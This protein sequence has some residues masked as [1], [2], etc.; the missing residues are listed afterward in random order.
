M[1]IFIILMLAAYLGGN[2]YICLRGWQALAH[3]PPAVRWIFGGLVWLSALSILSSFALRNSRMSASPWAHFLYEYSTGWLVFTLYMALFLL[4]GDLFRL[5]RDS[6]QYGFVCALALTACLLT[7][8]YLHYRRPSTQTVSLTVNKPVAG[9]GDTFR[10]VAVS[11]LHLGMGTPRAMLEQYVR[12]INGQQPDLIL[13]GGDLIDNSIVP[14]RERHMEQMLSQ[15]HA[16][17]G[18]Y[19]VPGNHEYISGLEDCAAFLR[20]TPIC[21]LRDSVATLPNGIRI[22]GRDD[23]GNRRRQPLSQLVAG[24]DTA[25]PVIVLDHQP[26]ALTQ[27]VEAG[28]DLLFCGH[29]HNGQVWPMNWLTGRL[30]EIAY[31]Y[32]KRGNTNMYVSSGLA[33]WGPPFRIGSRSE[34]VVFNLSFRRP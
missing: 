8:G 6:F 11:D 27:A 10:I 20:R 5:F 4:C 15:L 13:I 28:A 31:G 32:G 2:G 1:I 3:F 22:V 7:G 14:V 12:M 17:S 18:I 19:M 21:L 23:A 29:T 33:L 30:F 16:K 34:M 24:I 25:S 9:G 26:V